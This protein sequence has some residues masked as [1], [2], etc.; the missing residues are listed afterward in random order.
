MKYKIEFL[1]IFKALFLILTG[2]FLGTLI[3]SGIYKD[4]KVLMI[5]PLFQIFGILSFVLGV[6]I[7]LLPRIKP[8]TFKLGYISFI[9][10][11]IALFL[12]FFGQFFGFFILSF[13]IPLIIFSIIVFYNFLKFSLIKSNFREADP[14]FILSGFSLIGFSLFFLTNKTQVYNSNSI[15]FLLGFVGSLIYAIETRM[16]AVRQTINYKRITN[17]TVFFQTIS[18][19]LFLLNIFMEAPNYSIIFF[20]ISAISAIISLRIFEKSRP[21]TMHKLSKYERKMIYYNQATLIISYVWLTVSLTLFS[22]NIIHYD[23]L[24]HGVSL[25][26]IGNTILA[27]APIFLPTIL[28]K[29]NMLKV[30]S[31][32]IVVIYNIG[33]I[34]R[35]IKEL[36]DFNHLIS[37]SG[38]ILIASIL[39]F[40][41]KLQ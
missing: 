20:L 37:L 10:L 34:L 17:I 5:H 11:D 27:F 3:L 24:I 30:I 36:I 40:I 1:Y 39:I 13:E 7:F 33:V 14:F 18:I 9:F 6:A 25:G 41:M 23:S 38:L 21:L 22:F 16:V 15:L 4:Y 8:F 28:N 29:G 26:F 35:F 19:V 31:F 32:K 2:T 12:A